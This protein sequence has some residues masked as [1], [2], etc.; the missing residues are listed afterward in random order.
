MINNKLPDNYISK[1]FD[2]GNIIRVILMQSKMLLIIGFIGLATGIILYLNTP[3]QYQVTSLLQI[4]SNESKTDELNFVLGA[5]NTAN[6]NLIENLFKSR[7]NLLKVVDE[8][9]INLVSNNENWDLILKNLEIINLNRKSEDV[10]RAF[11]VNMLKNSYSVVTGDGK[12]YEKLK[13]DEFSEIGN[14][15]IFF[16]KHEKILE[17]KFSFRYIPKT[18]SYKNFKNKFDFSSNERRAMYGRPESNLINISFRASSYEKGIKILNHANKTFIDNSIKSEAET[19]RKAIK[20]IEERLNLLNEKLVFD[21]GNLNKLKEQNKSIDVNREIEAII[22]N[23]SEIDIK[24]S[25]I[26]IEIADAARLYTQTNPLFINLINKK[27]LLLLQKEVI[28]RKIMQLPLEQQKFIDLFKELELTQQ[29]YNTLM[30]KKLDLSI[31][32]ASTIGNIRI[33]DSAYPESQTAPQFSIIIISFIFSLVVGLISAI[34]RGLIF[35]PI[36]NPAEILDNGINVPIIG[37]L[38]NT[39]E[40]NDLDDPNNKFSQQKESLIL[41][42]E[43]VID[44]S[45]DINSKEAKVILFTGPT[46]E[47]GKS[48]LSREISKSFARLGKKILLIDLDLK[49]GDQHKDLKL[50]LFSLADFNNINGENIK[51]IEVENNLFVIPKIKKLDN[52]FNFLYSGILEKKIEVLRD[53]FDYIILD[54]APILSVPDTAL[55]MSLSDINLLVTRHALTKINEIKQTITMSS[56]TGIDFDGIIY[57]F[58]EKPSSYY[59]YYGLYG[60]YQY[61]YYANKYLYENYEYSDKD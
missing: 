34:I 9:K 58:Y 29:E 10:E 37:V 31:K 36:S 26:D 47:I 12:L 33:I 14:F 4:V 27:D 53:Y 3:K 54:T 60:N 59:G 20:Y 57:N 25:E 40:I 18:I 17:E 45:D 28:E 16:K 43:K 55:L 2:I 21:K 50:N 6:P 51:N 38:P 52:S 56:Q 35:L 42:L 5:E 24:L 39:D 22:Q 23:I 1:D 41:N 30:S 8:L 61:Q 44:D 46:P 13:Y 15:K 19:A 7:Q 48:L 32:E 11:E 49:R